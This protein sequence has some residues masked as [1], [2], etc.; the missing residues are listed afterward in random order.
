MSV[1]STIG[2]DIKKIFT[3]IGSASGQKTIATA[4]EIVVAIDPA[5]SGVVDLAENYIKQAFTIESVAVAASAQTGSGAQKL[6][7]VIAAVTP[8]ALQ[9]AQQAGA[10][11]PTA[12][13]IEAQAN[14]IV[15]FLNALPAAAAAA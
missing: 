15:A 5:L 6:A 4:G 1:L 9:Y 8:S 14:A 12:A 3:W 13:Q 2:K 7:A 10:P 11:A